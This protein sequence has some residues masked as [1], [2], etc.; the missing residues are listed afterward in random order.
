MLCSAGRGVGSGD[1]GAHRSPAR[2][3]CVERCSP[4]QLAIDFLFGRLAVEVLVVGLGCVSRVVDDA[5]P[6]IR[7]RVQ[8]VELQ[9]NRAGIDD[10]VLRPSGHDD[11]E[12]LRSSVRT[13]SRTATPAPSSTRKN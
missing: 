3:A 13:P 2:G 11:R 12:A 1:G 7:G 10:V 6:M 8:R 5:V 9:W 4:A